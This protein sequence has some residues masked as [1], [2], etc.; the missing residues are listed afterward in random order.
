MIR[1]FQQYIPNS[2]LW[3][4][5]TELLVSL[6]SVFLGSALWTLVA[7]YSPDSEATLP[8]ALLFCVVMA[9]AM[10]SMGLYQ[11]HLREGL[12][13]VTL[14]IIASSVLAATALG[15]V[16]YAFPD[17]SL[18]RGQLLFS[19]VSAVILMVVM[20][21]VFYRFIIDSGTLKRRIMVLG[22]G[23]RAAR[24]NEFKRKS[25][26]MTIDVVG[27]IPVEGDKVSVPEAMRIIPRAALAGTMDEFQIEELVVAADDRRKTLPVEDLLECKMNGVAVIDL[28]TFFEREHGIV[29][30]D[31]LQPSWLIFSEG[32]RQGPVRSL[33]KRTFD[34]AASLTILAFAWP[35]MV[36]GALAVWLECG[37]RGSILFRQERVGQAGRSFEL[38]KFRSMREDAESD[39]VARWAARN[40]SRITR[41]GAVLRR[42]RIDEL[43]QIFNVLRGDMSFVGPRPERPT[44]V[45]QLKESLPFY[46]ERHRVKPGITGWAQICYPYGASEKDAMHKLQFDL[47]YV[48]NYNVFLDI[49]ILMQTAEVV[50]WSKGAR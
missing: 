28:L 49:W 35:L 5:L 48:K 21:V 34:I 47:Y 36:L 24:I 40:D 18:S 33:V 46:S 45:D 11:R 4:S 20:R 12:T 29:K 15:L 23:E 27:F 10:V 14:R 22:A 8:R 38:L 1:L 13:G 26:R 30:L 19:L 32:F 31:I 42:S 25:D 16:F 44:F 9:M 43:P 3:L 37:G 7:G 39:G 2:F 17:V 50:V 41:V 6:A